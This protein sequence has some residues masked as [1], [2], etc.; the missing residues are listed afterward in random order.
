MTI[1]ELI[2]ECL[3]DKKGYFG[4]T[5]KKGTWKAT[6]QRQYI[7][8]GMGTTP[9]IAL[10]ELRD[11]LRKTE[12]ALQDLLAGKGNKKTPPVKEG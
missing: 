1:E 10:L 8:T 12:P 9:E 7:V 3:K 6:Y 11:L 5:Y 2:K 4:L